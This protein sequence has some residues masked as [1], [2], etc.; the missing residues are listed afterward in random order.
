M[1]RKV[2]PSFEMTWYFDFLDS[3]LNNIL[4]FILWDFVVAASSSIDIIKLNPILLQ[5]FRVKLFA[6]ISSVDRVLLSTSFSSDLDHLAT[7]P[8]VFA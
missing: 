5:N 4:I 2:M 8:P 6:E 3:R 7:S 1:E